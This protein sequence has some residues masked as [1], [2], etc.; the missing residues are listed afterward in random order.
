MQSRAPPD[1]EVFATAGGAS[2]AADP[3]N[4]ETGGIRRFEPVPLEEVRPAAVFVFHVSEDVLDDPVSGDVRS[5][6][7]AG[8]RVADEAVPAG[9]DDDAR[10]ALDHVAAELETSRAT[11][12]ENGV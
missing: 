11:F 5:E 8:R 3:R 9:P 7:D 4:L 12:D 1:D 6:G 2:S 10:T